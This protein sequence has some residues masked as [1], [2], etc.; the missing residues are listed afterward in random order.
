MLG[1]KL[2]IADEMDLGEFFRSNAEELFEFAGEMA[3][4]LKAED[5]G[6]F[7][8]RISAVEQMTGI[9]QTNLIEPLAQFQAVDVAEMTLE[10]PLGN[11]Q[12]RS[13]VLAGESGDSCKLGPIPDA[14]RPCSH[15]YRRLMRKRHPRGRTDLTFLGI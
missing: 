8:H 14:I 6:D 9:V 13:K 1:F 7:L 3:V 15:S 10:L 5:K 2:G 4:L 12:V 11:A